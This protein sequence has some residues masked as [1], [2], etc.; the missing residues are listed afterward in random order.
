VVQPGLVLIVAGA[1]AL[2]ISSRA[3]ADALQSNSVPSA[4]KLA[5]GFWIP[6]AM[7]A[8]TAMALNRPEIAIGVIFATSVASMSLVI[9]AVTFL[10]PPIVPI[11][12]RK[13]WPTLLPAAMLAF[14]AGFRSELTYLHG[15][16]LAIEGFILLW[17]WNDSSAEKQTQIRR[18]RHF[19]ALRL[20]QLILAIG[21]AFI[22]AWA[23]VRG[24]ERTS[25][26]SEV[27]S[28]GLLSASLLS[29]LLVLPM[30]GAGIDLAHRGQSAI[31]VTA[32]IAVAIL[33]LCLLLPL[34][35]A[36]GYVRTL[37][38]NHCQTSLLFL[39]KFFHVDSAPSPTIQFPLAVWRADV[40]SL[41]ALSLFL[42]PVSQGRW[43]LSKG[44]GMALIIAYAAYLLLATTLGVRMV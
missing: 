26:L 16:I 7:V 42:L 40:V 10:S 28:A 39:Q 41:I 20:I 22:G 36:F 35:I 3:A 37:A 34:V 24:T 44:N 9:G 14:L 2:Y 1:V 5:V 33:N 30:L 32:Q 17:I 13:I 21:L 31:S 8:L 15:I 11:T 25:Q 27:A 19:P 38:F 6:V 43:A 12:A 4:G 29:P 18:R 23:G